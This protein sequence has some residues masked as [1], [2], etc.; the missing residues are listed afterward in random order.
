M[1][2]EMSTNILNVEMNKFSFQSKY[3]GTNSYRQ[4][5]LEM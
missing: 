1:L 4:H 5:I 2:T 3:V